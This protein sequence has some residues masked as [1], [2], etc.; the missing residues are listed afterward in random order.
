MLSMIFLKNKE[1]SLRKFALL[2]L[3]LQAEELSLRE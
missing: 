1:D 2:S 3:E